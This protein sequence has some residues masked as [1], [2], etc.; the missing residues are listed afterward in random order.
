MTLRDKLLANKPQLTPIEI[1]GETYYL[2]D[3]TVGDMNR[4]IFEFRRWLIEQAEIEG[5]ELPPQ[6]DD[7][8]DDELNRFGEKYR[9]PQSLAARLCDEQGELLFNPLSL[10]D[11]NAIA[12]LDS[13]VIID[14]NQAISPPKASASEESS[15]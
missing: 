5:V 3:T 15:S 14:F 9:L 13:Q 8:F 2:R 7:D 11:I 4:Q 1:N 10:D 6:D 12:A